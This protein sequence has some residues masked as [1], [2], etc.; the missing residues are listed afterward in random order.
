MEILSRFDEM[1]ANAGDGNLGAEGRQQAAALIKA[2]V[3]GR[4][5]VT[6]DRL[7]GVRRAWGRGRFTPAIMTAIRQ[8]G[9]VNTGVDINLP[10]ID[11]SFRELPRYARIADEVY[12]LYH[13]EEP[14]TMTEIGKRFGTNSGNVWLAYKFWHESRGLPVPMKRPG[15]QAKHNRSA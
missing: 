1:L 10:E 3:G 11:L 5:V 13:Q 4:I 6:F 7:H 2:L 14:M 15:V 8:D 12:R 9:G